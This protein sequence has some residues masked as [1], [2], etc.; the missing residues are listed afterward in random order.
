M[1]IAKSKC[2]A[3]FSTKSTSGTTLQKQPQQ[4]QLFPVLEKLLKLLKKFDEIRKRGAR[5]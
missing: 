3:P 5:N 1:A 2:K 4:Q